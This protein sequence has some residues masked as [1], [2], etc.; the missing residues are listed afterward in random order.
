MK[1]QKSK[2]SKTKKLRKNKVMK[3]MIKIKKNNEIEVEIWR[4]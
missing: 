1:I 2:I 4:K 3:K